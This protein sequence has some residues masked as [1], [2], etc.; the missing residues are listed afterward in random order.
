M[1]LGLGLIAADS[2]FK[3]GDRREVRDYNRKLRD[4]EL[5]LLPD[6]TEATR[7]GYRDTLA[8]NE[9][10]GQERPGR[11]AN[12]LKR[13]QIEATGL[14]RAAGRQMTLE[15]T[16]DAKAA[17]GL[18]DA[19]MTLQQQPQRQQMESD[20]LKVEAAGA[21]QAVQ[22]LPQRLAAAAAAGTLQQR[23][24]QIQLIAGLE[25][26]LA[27]NNPQ[28]V[29][30]YVQGAIDTGLFPS[31][32]GAKVAK[33]GMA[34]DGRFIAQ[35]QDGAA[36]F[37]VSRDD[38][39]RLKQ[40]GGKTELKTVNAGD[41]LVQVQ[42][43]KATPLYTA[44]ESEKSKASKTGPLERDVNYLV[45]SHGMTQQQALAHMNAAKSMS[46]QQFILKGL[47]GKAGLGQ[48]PTNEDIAELGALYDR[49][50]ASAPAASGQ[51]LG[52]GSA[53]SNSGATPTMPTDPATRRLLGIP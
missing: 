42:G 40:L 51:G 5:S 3:E 20:K 31:V 15:D 19:R 18:S 39:A 52:L 44:P 2:Y 45:Q 1:N 41:S 37:S 29:Q 13:Q 10:R 4:S 9:A 26:A 38:L 23:D 47:E 33:V 35:G 8:E 17:A 28:L 24:A 49:A 6:K 7:S 36:I 48:K 27:T 12:T 16:A 25:P 30:Q 21:A 46:R 34:A 43:G 53:Q 50:A 14:D 11:T 32:Q 22:Q